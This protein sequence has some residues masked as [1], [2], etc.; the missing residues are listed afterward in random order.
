MQ[1]ETRS[2]ASGD[3]EA[4]HTRLCPLT[5]REINFEIQ[6]V[7]NAVKISIMLRCGFPGEVGFGANFSLRANLSTKTANGI[8]VVGL[9]VP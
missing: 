2:E 5:G 9:Q 4:K 3:V 8:F 1:Q 7:G 6:E